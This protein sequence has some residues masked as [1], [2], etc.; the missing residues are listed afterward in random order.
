MASS[1]DSFYSHPG[2]PLVEH[3]DAVGRR[4]RAILEAQGISNGELL[5][6][7]ELVGK[8]HDFGKYTIYFQRYIKSSDSDNKRLSINDELRHHSPLSALFCAWLVNRKLS[9][10]LLTLASLASVKH[11]HGSLYIP[12]MNDLRK[13]VKDF[14]NGNV[15]RKQLKSLEECLPQIENELMS[16]GVN[17]LDEF[18]TECKAEKPLK[19]VLDVLKKLEEE[20]DD[21]V[22]DAFERMYVVQLIFSALIAADKSEAGHILKLAKDMSDRPRIPYNFIDSHRPKSSCSPSLQYV[23]EQ[24]HKRAHQTLNALIRNNKIP[25]IMKITAPTGAGKTATALSI[26]LKLREYIEK[27]EEI[28]PRIIYCLPYI[29]IIEQ[30]HD[31]ISK[32]LEKEGLEPE[33]SILLK[34]HHLSLVT[35]DADDEKPVE[36][37]LLAVDSWDSEIIVTTFVQLFETLLGIRNRMLLKFHKL[38]GSIII[39]DEVQTLRMELWKLVRDALRSLSKHSWIILMSA[40]SPDML[41]PEGSVELVQGYEELYDVLDRVTYIYRNEDMTPEELAHFATDLWVNSNPSSMAVI[42]NTIPSS[43]HVY[44]EIKKALKEE[45]IPLTNEVDEKDLHDMDEAVI[46][47]LSTNIIPRERLRRIKIMKKLLE[48][49]RRVILVCTQVI[50]AGVDLDFDVLIR[51][52]APLD[53]II[54]S[55]GRCNR[56]GLKEKGQVY[57]IKV[58][59][60]GKPTYREVYGRLSVEEATLPVLKTEIDESKILET[61]KEYFDKVKIIKSLEYS[62]ESIKTLEHIKN[63]W[64]IELSNFSLIEK[65]PQ[66]SIFIEID[67]EAKEE[68]EKFK[69]IL[70]LYRIEKTFNNRTLLRLHRTQLENYIVETW[71]KKGVPSQ[72]IAPNLDIRYVG[73][74]EVPTYYDLETGLKVIDSVQTHFW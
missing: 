61:I 1:C 50:E 38:F 67:N 51:D 8:L 2:K 4:A 72:T 5:K 49:G 55:G 12:P 54:Q 71:Y 24:V 68:L 30:T 21:N 47:Y 39:L 31:V 34:H 74:D 17:G 43:I 3:L 29:N 42:L 26:A 22:D 70:A 20:I 56:H 41:T 62:E 64:L 10:P 15:V 19:E 57:I 16:I 63:L 37:R 60:D 45:V 9:R 14:L 59:A 69:S 33:P 32:S 52:L 11:H 6:T 44:H 58:V 13:W 28:T 65:R 25:R 48:E 36:D 27:T 23:R 7:A 18:L 35:D 66:I 53:S 73:K 40:T 46:G